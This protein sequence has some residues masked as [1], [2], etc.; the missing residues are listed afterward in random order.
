LPRTAEATGHVRAIVVTP[1]KGAVRGALRRLFSS[2]R[3][4]P[5]G[6]IGLL[7]SDLD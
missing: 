1:L 2:L 3:A 5:I 6:R 7:G 4:L